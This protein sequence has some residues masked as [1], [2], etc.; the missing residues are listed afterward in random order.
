MRVSGTA[1]TWFPNATNRVWK[2]GHLLLATLNGM[3]SILTAI[4]SAKSKFEMHRLHLSFLESPS[5]FWVFFV[6]TT[7]PCRQSHMEQ[8]HFRNSMGLSSSI[9]G[10][11][12]RQLHSYPLI[13]ALFQFLLKIYD[14]HG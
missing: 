7:I 10:N 6:Y 1:D 3:G 9:N 13:V 14:K 12:G 8:A 2:G 11:G 4:P 5:H